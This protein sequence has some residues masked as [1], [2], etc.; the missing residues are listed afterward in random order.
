M[1]VYTYLTTSRLSDAKQ[2]NQ[3]VRHHRYNNEQVTAMLESPYMWIEQLR[4]AAKQR[5]LSV[6][7]VTPIADVLPLLRGTV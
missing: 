7:S 2:R 4:A 3:T 6:T 5:G 1:L